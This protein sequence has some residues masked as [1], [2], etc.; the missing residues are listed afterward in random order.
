FRAALETTLKKYQNIITAVLFALGLLL[1]W[2]ATIKHEILWQIIGDFGTFMAGVV[3]IQFIYE[4]YIKAEEQ[5][6]F[7]SY[8]KAISGSPVLFL[9]EKRGHLSKEYY[10]PKSAIAK[11]IDIITLSMRMINEEYAKGD[12]VRWVVKDGKNF[13]ILVLS[14]ESSSAILIGRQEGISLP[15]KIKGEIKRLGNLHQQFQKEV[16]KA[17]MCKG[18]LEVRYYDGI[19]YYAYFKADHEIIIGLYYSHIVGNESEC[20]LVK[21]TNEPVYADVFRN[22]VDHFEIL[23]GD[24]NQPK[25]RGRVICR[26]GSEGVYFKNKS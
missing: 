19:P 24:K 15:D 12:L 21:E 26:I 20:F 9:P 1:R 23:W 7:L 25:T 8:I 17:G 2:L 11:N 3:G 16:D 13:R 10:L 5:R 4:R 22:F 18:S 6:V 14:P